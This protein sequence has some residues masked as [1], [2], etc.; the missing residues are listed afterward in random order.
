MMMRVR[1]DGDE[2]LKVVLLGSGTVGTQV[3]RLILEHG[4]DFAARI[5]DPWN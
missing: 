2:P 5:G 1:Q 3:A 4:D